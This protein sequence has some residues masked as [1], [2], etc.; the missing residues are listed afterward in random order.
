MPLCAAHG[1]PGYRNKAPARA[2]W[3]TG[4]LAASARTSCLGARSEDTT[5]HGATRTGPT[6]GPNATVSGQHLRKGP[7]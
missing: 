2:R 3:P 1:R 5:A 6:S 7:E 4:P